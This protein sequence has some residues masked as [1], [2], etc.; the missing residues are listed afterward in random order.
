MPRCI[1][2]EREVCN[3]YDDHAFY[4]HRMLFTSVGYRANDERGFGCRW[5]ER[6]PKS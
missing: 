1:V 3:G 2:F 4:R 5:D 6:F